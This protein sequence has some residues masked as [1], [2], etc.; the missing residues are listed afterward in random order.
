MRTALWH[1][2]SRL[3]SGLPFLWLKF[4]DTIANTQPRETVVKIENT[5]LTKH[6]QTF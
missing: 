1:A 3:S 6:N 4:K 2:V 5:T